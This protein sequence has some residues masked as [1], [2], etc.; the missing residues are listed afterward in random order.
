MS[1]IFI[2]YRRK[3]TPLV[4]PINERLGLIYGKEN[5]FFDK[6]DIL[7]GQ[8][9]RSSLENGVKN[10]EAFMLVISS[11]WISDE[12]FT[13]LKEDDDQVRKEIE[14]AIEFKKPIFP[15]LIDTQKMPNKDLL[16]ESIQD[17]S[18]SDIQF[19]LI[20]TG[21]FD[22]YAE[23]L[24]KDMSNRGIKPKIPTK[25]EILTYIESDIDKALEMLDQIF[26]NSYGIYNDLS[27]EYYS[28]PNSFSIARYRSRLKA[29]V[30]RNVNV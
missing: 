22:I 19:L 4:L 12:G 10:C 25:Q 16:P 15:I 8:N 9:W 1:Q 30:R 23:K 29:F 21:N 5:V 27:E 18:S 17:I 14:W 2:S 3:D 6:E 13:R 20:D 24:L 26:G 11:Y 7:T 28:Q